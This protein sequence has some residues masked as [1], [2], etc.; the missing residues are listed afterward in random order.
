LIAPVPGPTNSKQSVELEF[1]AFVYK[2]PDIAGRSAPG[3]KLIYL[4]KPAAIDQLRARLNLKK[5]TTGK[6]RAK[7]SP[8]KGLISSCFDSLFIDV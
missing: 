8:V 6:L 4:Q 7:K 5:S 2:I 3:F 1:S